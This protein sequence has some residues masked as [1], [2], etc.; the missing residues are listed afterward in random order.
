MSMAF[1][2]TSLGLAAARSGPDPRSPLNWDGGYQKDPSTALLF[3][4]NE[5]RGNLA[6]DESS[7]GNFGAIAVA[8]WAD[9]R[10]GKGLRFDG[11]NDYVRVPSSPSLAIAGALTLEAWI[12]PL[13]IMDGVGTLIVKDGSYLL[14]AVEGA[15][16]KFRCKVWQG[17]ASNTL[18][19]SSR[20]ES[21]LWQHLAMTFDGTALRLYLNGILDAHRNIGP[22]AIAVNANDVF[23]GAHPAGNPS[24]VSNA[25]LD[26]VRIS[27]AAR[28][29]AELAPNL[30]GT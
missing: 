12:F 16:P 25:V 6:H 17:A 11:I 21:S 13:A 10:H 8:E 7:F 4:L 5:G 27:S 24:R 9:G 20:V 2:L 1:S 18:Q 29:A 14:E 19:S 30:E 3:K 15:A 23:I 28:A 22:G 26:E